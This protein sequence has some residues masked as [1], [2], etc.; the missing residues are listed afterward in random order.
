MPRISQPE[1]ML[2][3]ALNDLEKDWQIAIS[4]WRDQAKQNF[5]KAYVNEL[6]PAGRTAAT[7]MTELTLL[8]RRVVR[9]CN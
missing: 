6:Q 2:L 8:L 3:S 9:E 4:D 5:E 7:A 1:Q